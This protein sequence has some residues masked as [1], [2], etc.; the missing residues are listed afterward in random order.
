MTEPLKSAGDVLADEIER[1]K[2]IGSGTISITVKKAE[3]LLRAIRAG[4]KMLELTKDKTPDM[5]DRRDQR[6]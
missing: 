4:E 5:F 1:S 6:F 2:F 3:E